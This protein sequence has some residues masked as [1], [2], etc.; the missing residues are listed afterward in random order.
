MKMALLLALVLLACG[1][2]ACG[3][4]VYPATPTNRVQ[5]SNAY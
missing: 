5:D 3:Q 1:L 2:E 4:R